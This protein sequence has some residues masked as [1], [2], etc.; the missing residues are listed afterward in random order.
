[1]NEIR[2]YKL[3]KEDDGTARAPLV[4]PW[5]GEVPIGARIIYAYHRMYPYHCIDVDAIVPVAN[6]PVTRR[7]H[8]VNHACCGTTLGPV[9]DVTQVVRVEAPDGTANGRLYLFEEGKS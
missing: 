6:V 3:R 8:L 1:M 9:L 5:V 2:S 7:F 4:G